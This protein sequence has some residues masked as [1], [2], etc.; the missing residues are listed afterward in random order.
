MRLAR[1]GG[2]SSVVVRCIHLDIAM[3][4]RAS[5]R[6]GHMRQ[7]PVLFV[8]LAVAIVFR[9]PA[10]NADPVPAQRTVVVLAAA[11]LT[12]AFTSIGKRFEATQPG[13]AVQSS[14]ASS[15]TLVTQ[16]KEGSPGDV[17]ASADES[18]MQAA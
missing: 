6:T 3:G 17:F 12:D 11:S 7:L 4:R 18:T 2:L 15:S 14:F 5:E 1:R 13:V 8:A 9:P 16:I 10:V